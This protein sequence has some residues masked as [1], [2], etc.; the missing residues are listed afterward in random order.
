MLSSEGPKSKQDLCLLQLDTIKCSLGSTG[1]YHTEEQRNI[2]QIKNL[3][4]CTYITLVVN[5]MQN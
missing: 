3:L 5:L 4:C 2:Y 1:S